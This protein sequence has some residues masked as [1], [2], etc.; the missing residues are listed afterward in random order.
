MPDSHDFS[1]RLREAI[2]QKSVYTFSVESGIDQSLLGKYLNGK[3]VPGLDKLVQIAEAAG[4]T[5]GWLAAGESSRTPSPYRSAPVLYA[6]EPHTGG[7]EGIPVY[8]SVQAGAL[9]AYEV[10]PWAH[11]QL[12]IHAPD[13]GYQAGTLFG[14][15][16]SG[17][18]CAPVYL[19]GDTVVCSS[20]LEPRAGQDVVAYWA[21]TGEATLKRLGLIEQGGRVVLMPLNPQYAPCE[22]QLEEQDRLFVVVAL[23]RSPVQGGLLRTPEGPSV[24]GL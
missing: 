18:S 16:V 15:R 23:W 13:L 17:D 21:G 20:V 3:S 1:S 19:P 11:E 4:V 2:G 8:A 9:T 5:V 7:F 14:L 6:R 10:D 24:S 22:A 12:P